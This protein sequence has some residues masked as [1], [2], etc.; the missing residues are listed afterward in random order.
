MGRLQLE[1]ASADEQST[2]SLRRKDER[3]TVFTR[4][5]RLVR[6]G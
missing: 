2:C 6:R 4:N 3:G 1:P 5:L